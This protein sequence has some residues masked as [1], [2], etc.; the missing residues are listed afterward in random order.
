MN[1]V[2][3]KRGLDI[4]I[5]GEADKAYASPK[6]IDFFGISPL[7]FVGLVPDLKV[8]VGN[9]VYAGSVLFT[10]F[11][12]QQINIVSPVSGYIDSIEKKCDGQVSHIVIKSDEKIIYEHFSEA[13]PN[14]L[15][16][17]EIKN[18]LLKSGVW[19]FIRQRPFDFIASPND[20]PKAIFVSAFDS[21][22]LAPDF[23]FI[24]H[25]KGEVFQTGIDALSKLVDG[26]LHLSINA[27]ITATKVF[28]KTRNAHIH[29]F[30]GPHPAGNIGIQIHH[31]S[32][33]NKGEVVWYVNAQDVLIIGRLFIEGV[34]NAGRIIALAG[35]EVRH[36]KYHK[37]FIG[38][39]IKPLLEENLSDSKLRIING[40]VL[41]GK[42][43][44]E[45]GF[46][47]YYNHQIS[48]IPEGE[49]A[50][51]FGWAQLRLDKFSHSRSYFSRIIPSMKY[52]IDTNINGELRPFFMSGQ[53]ESVLPM[54][55]YPVFLLKAILKGDIDQMEKLGIYEVSEE[56]FALCEYICTSKIEVQEI[57][58]MGLDLL[59]KD[60]Q[61]KI[62]IFK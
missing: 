56:D 24:H 48:V 62:N 17:E 42:T 15:S 52:R 46:L 31:I 22:P 14:E 10:D 54:D 13:N 49:N 28:T 58:R 50:E 55:I 41:T 45:N 16:A 18:R 6:Q 2:K 35:S 40:N 21:S 11:N 32:P 3:I 57:I 37:T 29:Y 27:D 59:R 60:K 12:N 43:T 8:E 44:N 5:E 9:K 34:F 1:I 36:P 47:G 20:I 33:I 7:D 30:S 39:Q 25:G 61:K 51:F 26:N 19:A 4:R 38:A 53:Y 23:D